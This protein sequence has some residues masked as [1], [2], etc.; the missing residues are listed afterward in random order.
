MTELH[1]ENGVTIVLLQMAYESLDDNGIEQLRGQL[2]AAAE[3]PCLVI[4]FSETSFIGSSFIDVLLQAY[5]R[6][7]QHGGK[8]A[9]AQLGPHCAEVLRVTGM[10][11]I[12][13]IYPSRQ[14][15]IEAVS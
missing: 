11:H 12:W 4:D 1:T 13:D 3:S 15:A 6:V 2:L 14:E 10:D 9:L 8:M 5:K 7:R